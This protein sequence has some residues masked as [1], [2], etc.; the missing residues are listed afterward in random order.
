MSNER[1]NIG[2][3]FIH[4][5]TPSGEAKVLP[6]IGDALKDARIV[7]CEDR[8]KHMQAE[9][10]AANYRA[11]KAEARITRLRRLVNKYIEQA[12]VGG[13]SEREITDAITDCA[14][15]GDLEEPA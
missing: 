9:L 7:E 3:V 8:I 2:G 11:S 10:S 13:I 5:A 14:K 12:T 15:H 1:Q 4:P 6:H